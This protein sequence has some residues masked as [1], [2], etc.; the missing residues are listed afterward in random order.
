M[1]TLN[2]T[3]TLHICSPQS[4]S[5]CPPPRLSG[6]HVPLLSIVAS[7]SP[8]L[9][10]R[11]DTLA[12]CQLSH[13]VVFDESARI[14]ALSPRDLRPWVSVPLLDT[15]TRIALPYAQ[16]QLPLA[17]FS[18]I[19]AGSLNEVIELVANTPCA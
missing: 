14:A 15:S 8:P 19:E 11:F 13:T 4:P 18:V 7:V 9:R 2:I 17:G 12:Q 3:L 1:L 10:F 5:V 16:P 6:R